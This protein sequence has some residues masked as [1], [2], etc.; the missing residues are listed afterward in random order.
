MCL[1]NQIYQSIL[2]PKFYYKPKY[3][4]LKSYER[5]LKYVVIELDLEQLEIVTNSTKPHL[6]IL[7]ID[8]VLMTRF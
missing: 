8:K 6:F 4:I 5:V 3:F 2:S 1:F 7:V